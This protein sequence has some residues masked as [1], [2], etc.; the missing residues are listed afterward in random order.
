M[1][2][3]YPQL[4]WLLLLLPL[5]AI[6]RGRLGSAPTLLFS[7]TSLI[8]SL[9]RGKKTR[10]TALLAA[11]RLAV[12]ALLILAAARPQQGNTTSQIQASGIDILLAVDVSGSMEAMDFTLNE[13]AVNRLAVVK[14]VVDEFI[15]ERPNDRIGLVAFGG[16]PYLVCPLTLD[17]DWLRKRLESLS[18]GMVEDG[19]AI[20]S[21]I[22]SGIIRLRD[23]EAKSR[24]LILLTDGMSNA[25][26]VPPLVA[27]EAAEALNIKVYTIGVGTRG[28]APMPVTDP[29]GR[30]QIRLVRVD[31]DEKTLSAVAEKTGT[32]Y[33]RAT[34]TTSLARIYEDINRMETTTRTIKK[35]ENSWELFPYLVLA[36]LI[37]LACEIGGRRR[38]L[39]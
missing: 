18:I 39:P 11:V 24:I 35:F 38:Q 20:G 29:F 25:G 34:D 13:Q 16:R 31:I 28:E 5:L 2:F 37:L 36:A 4:L 22:G 3:L 21:A 15:R 26:R 9:A 23:Q 17:H 1:R 19:T 27:A 6:V 12:L 30:K 10:P 7:S 8:A 32:Q 14:K 33:F